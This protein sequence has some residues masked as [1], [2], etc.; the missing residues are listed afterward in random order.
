M[1]WMQNWILAPQL[2]ARAGRAA[3]SQVRKAA[4][5]LP[6]LAAR[7]VE[8]EGWPQLFPVA[9]AGSF[10]G[11]WCLTRVEGPGLKLA[12]AWPGVKVSL[13]GAAEMMRLGPVLRR[14]AGET[15]SSSEKLRALGRHHGSEAGRVPGSAHVGQELAACL[16]AALP[17]TSLRCSWGLSQTAPSARPPLMG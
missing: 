3:G 2:L 15:E 9:P 12:L 11:S 14:S 6:R 1:S 10:L 4:S 17:S 5:S 16:A 8:R 13:G 7:H